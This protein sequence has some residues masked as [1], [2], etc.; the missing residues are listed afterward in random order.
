MKNLGKILLVVAI[1]GGVAYAAKGSKAGTVVAEGTYENK[2]QIAKW[3]IRELNGENT[4]YIQFPGND[5]TEIATQG[6]LQA[7]GQVIDSRM[8]ENGFLPQP[9]VGMESAPAQAGMSSVSNVQRAS[10]S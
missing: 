4:A 9:G 8:R 1:V 7:L 6:T 3:E 10:L 5:W 2:G